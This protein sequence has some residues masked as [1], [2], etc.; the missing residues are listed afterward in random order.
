MNKLLEIDA[1]VVLILCA[2]VALWITAHYAS[3]TLIS[4][5]GK[6]EPAE[7]DEDELRNK[8]AAGAMQAILATSIN[9]DNK[10]TQAWVAAAAWAQADEML[11]AK[12]QSD[13]G[14]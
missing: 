13:D 12:H 14:E 1:T 9:H 11:K 3:E 10:L 5:F 2:V 4:I 7:P 6:P 8:L